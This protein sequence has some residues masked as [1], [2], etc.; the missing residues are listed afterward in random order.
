M[1]AATLHATPEFQRAISAVERQYE[2]RLRVGLLPLTVG[3][4]ERLLGDDPKA[5][6]AWEQYRKLEEAF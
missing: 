2:D 5:L 4:I 1:T 6:A 3:S